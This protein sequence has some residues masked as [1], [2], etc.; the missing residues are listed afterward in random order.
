MNR[1][2]F[3]IHGYAATKNSP[4]V[5]TLRRRFI[6]SGYDNSI[7]YVM[8]LSR[9]GIPG[10]CIDS[11]QQYAEEVE[12]RI[13]SIL[14]DKS[15][16]EV[17]MIAHSMGGLVARWYVEELG[18]SENVNKLITLAT[19]HRGTEMASL[20]FWTS[21]GGDMLPDSEFLEKLN[22]SPLADDVEYI[23]IWSKGDEMVVPSERAKLEGAKNIHAGLFTHIFLPTS[24]TVFNEAILPAL[25]KD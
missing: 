14:E 1:P 12:E 3:I 20:V 9:G 24:R 17:D 16:E 11:P 7:V 18:G 10:T 15:F 23:S 19:P 21:G 13:D 8:D 4:W 25:K 5:E 6:E 2:V 22:S